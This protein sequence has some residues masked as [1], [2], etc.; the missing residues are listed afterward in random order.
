ML[1]ADWGF[2]YEKNDTVLGLGANRW[3]VV[4]AMRIC[5]VFYGYRRTKSDPAFCAVLCGI[6]SDRSC[7]LVFLENPS[8]CKKAVD[9]LAKKLYDLSVDCRASE[10]DNFLLFFCEVADQS[11][12]H[13]KQHREHTENTG[14]GSLRSP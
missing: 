5:D 7:N 12:M 3:F 6:A 14:D 11:G 13:L 2:L 4:W 8:I 1:V 10:S 9:Y